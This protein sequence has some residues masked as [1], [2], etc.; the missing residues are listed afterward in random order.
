VAAHQGQTAGRH[1]RRPHLVEVSGGHATPAG[2]ASRNGQSRST[3][4][5]RPG[6]TESV[7]ATRN[8]QTESV[9]AT[10]AGQ[11]GATRATRGSRHAA[12]AGW[13]TWVERARRLAGQARAWWAEGTERVAVRARERWN[14]QRGDA[15]QGRSGGRPTPIRPVDAGSGAG[16]E[17][18]AGAGV[19]VGLRPASGAR[20]GTRSG[21]RGGST[22]A[23]QRTRSA[24]PA[25]RHL[26]EA[27]GARRAGRHEDLVTG[28]CSVLLVLGL[29]REGWSRAN[30]VG[31]G[32]VLTIWH[33]VLAAGLV[34]TAG[35]IL[36]RDQRRGAW[37]LWAVPAGYRVALAGLVLAAVALAGDAVWHG[38]FGPGPG[39]ARLVA[40]FHLALF[41]GA[42]LL[43][44]STLRA[45]WSGPSPARVP[46]LRG[47]WSVVLSAMLLVAMT[48]WFFQDVAPVAAGLPATGTAQAA[49]TAPMGGL[50][51]LL[52]HNLLLVAPMLLLLL[53]WQTPLGTFTVLA[54]SVSLLLATQSGLGLVGLAG[55]AVLGG[56]AADVA[57]TMLRPSPQRRWAARAVAVIVPA[58]WWT[59]HFALLGAGYGVGPDL[60]LWLGSTIWACLSGLTLALLMWPP[61]VPLTAWNRGRPATPRSTA[62]PAPMPTS[63]PARMVGR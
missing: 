9:R 16:L 24:E 23:A 40:P 61:A 60:E 19:R 55:A 53:R 49:G 25:P 38:M 27:T 22:S 62:Q 3:R 56:A 32:P 11:A 18:T 41:A 51:G 1:E 21:S 5:T 14:E 26:A 2:R 28:W 59:S 43:V 4:A 13:A 44:G 48:V 45:A 54:G 47:F 12:P 37:S 17:G 10:R 57:V 36:T 6:R 63:M 46:G 8:G 15:R 39:L 29:Y 42:C 52:A 7:G 58:V 34:A 30:P 20:G 33:G 31:G 50:L 35:W